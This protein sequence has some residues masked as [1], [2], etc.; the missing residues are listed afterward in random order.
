LRTATVTLDGTTV[1]VDGELGDSDDATPGGCELLGVLVVPVPP[2][3]PPSRWVTANTRMTRTT[4]APATTAIVRRFGGRVR[5][6]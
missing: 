3:P 2:P 4:N 5:G 6:R 1:V